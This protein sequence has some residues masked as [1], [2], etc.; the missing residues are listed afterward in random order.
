MADREKY[1]PFTGD[2]D[3]SVRLANAPLVLV[4]C[5]VRWPG[6]GSLQSEDQLRALAPMF[7]EKVPSYPLFSEAKNINYVI[8]PEGI[9]QTTAGNIYQWASADDVW[10]I[11]LARRFI[12]VYCNHYSDYDV[13][14]TR[15]REALEALQTVVQVPIVDRVGVRYV[16]RVPIQSANELNEL[17]P[18]EVL[19]LQALSLQCPGPE[20]QNATNQAAYSVDGATLLVRSGVFPPNSTVD[21][22]I[23]PLTDTASWVLDLDSSVEQRQLFVVDSVATTAS[24]MSD[25]AY[26]Y[27]KLIVKDAFIQRFTEE[28]S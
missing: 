17:V 20:L 27:F 19:G 9:N 21:P 11:S 26:D 18:S 22:A 7:G 15:L 6:L 1:R 13:F 23:P 14:D 12:T 3:K 25:I 28:E 8:T 16:N 4:L 5:Q 2:S 10:H 24:R